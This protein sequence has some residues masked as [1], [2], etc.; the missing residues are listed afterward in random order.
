MLRPAGSVV[1]DLGLWATSPLA[2][3][4][5]AKG[6]L[7]ASGTTWRAMVSFAI[8]SSNLQLYVHLARGSLNR[9]PTGPPLPTCARARAPVEG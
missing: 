5:L 8:Y 6:T 7:G 9:A 3:P 1:V 2:T 4:G